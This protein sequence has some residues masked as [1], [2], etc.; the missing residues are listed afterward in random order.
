[1]SAMRETILGRPRVSFYA[2]AALVVT[3]CWIVMR[4]RAFA[5]NPDVAAW[6]VT[7]DLTI[8]L[9][10]LYWMLVVRTGAALPLTIVPVFAAGSLLGRFIIPAAQQRFL[11]QLG[12][13]VGLVAEVAL[14]AAVA[15]RFVA[16]RRKPDAG[17]DTPARLRRVA[18][19]IAGD[20]RIAG[21]LASELTMFYYALFCWRKRA[22]IEARAFT[23]HR[24]S[25]WGTIAICLAVMI[26]AES[27]GMHLLLLMWSAKAAWLWTA[28]D[29]WALVWI[30]GDYHALRLRPSLVD[31]D[32][33]HLRYGMRWNLTVPL[34]GIESVTPVRN[35]S[36]WK[37]RGTLKVA[38]L[39]DP[40]WLI[41]LREPLM[42][43]GLAGIRKRVHAIAIL[44]DDEGAIQGLNN[45]VR[46]ITSGRA[47]VAA[48]VRDEHEDR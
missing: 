4:S 26:V 29:V 44:P 22:E 42:A 15:R 30:A 2:A 11:H 8:T 20:G 7:F 21:V 40:S 45:D 31:A 10:V 6:G 33:L 3:A 37:Q 13:V 23:V 17:G 9:P 24:R 12:F 14:V 35:E 41:T 32:A 16:M 18:V 36:D 28:M 48:A 46:L 39:E 47:R 43:T 34:E 5:S 38:L 27:I 19:A 25:G 1:M